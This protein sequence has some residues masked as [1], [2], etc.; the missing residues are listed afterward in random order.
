[1]TGSRRGP[2]SDED[3]IASARRGPLDDAER[4]ELEAVLA[5]DPTLRLAHDVG[6][7]FDDV[8]VV[9]PGDEALIARVADRTLGIETRPT[10]ARRWRIGAAVAAGF[11]LAA[12]AAGAYWA[13]I[14][15]GVRPTPA[16]DGHDIAPSTPRLRSKARATAGVAEA[17]A[18]SAAPVAPEPAP[19]AAD[20]VG[21]A[22]APAGP[23]PGGDPLA[24]RASPAPLDGRSIAR[25][26]RRADPAGPRPEVQPPPAPT[27]PATSAGASTASNGNETAADLFRRAGAARRAGWLAA[28]CALYDELQARF[29]A[30]EESRLS[31]VSQ[32]KLLLTMGR[33]QEAERHFAG[34]LAGGAG[35]LAAEATFGRAQSFE[36]MGRP[37][38]EREVWLGLLRDFPGSVYEGAA[39]RRIADLGD[40]PR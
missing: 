32:G 7:A 13:G 17:P 8:A 4:R 1:M 3:L 26:V 37:R 12:S 31:H 20:P 24:V 15:R 39:R 10:A 16:T 28:A 19:G 27:G 11:L 22:L 29:P 40:D 35:S 9:R 38:E 33:P 18:P 2:V 14:I 21:P 25:H 6:R 30:A 5:T 36:R 23:D 34:Y